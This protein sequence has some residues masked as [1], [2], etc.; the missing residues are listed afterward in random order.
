M[1]NNGT[2]KKSLRLAMIGLRGIPHTYG[3]GEEFIKYLGPAL[4]D[5][6]HKVTVYCRS[7]EFREDRA[8]YYQGV[9]RV[10]LPTI[11]HKVAGQFIHAS[12]AMLRSLRGFNVIYVHTLPSAPHSLL[13]WLLRRKVV[14][15]TDGLDWERSKWG[16]AAR[17][18]F[19]LGARNLGAHRPGAGERLA[20]NA[21]VL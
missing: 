20:R 9:R 1:P 8:P 18:Y 7:A 4:A 12:L 21:E 2:G 3:G 15:N 13:P 6:G 16:G 14:I 11:D 10:F 17:R 19:K 5:R